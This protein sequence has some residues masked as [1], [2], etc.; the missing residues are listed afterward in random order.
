[1]ENAVWLH[2]KT[3]EFKV[4]VGELRAGEIDFVASRGA[5]RIYIQ[6]T[7]IMRPEETERREFGNLM[8]INDN[9]PKYLVPME[10]VAGEMP[11]YPGIIRMHL[12]EFLKLKL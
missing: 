1:M 7:C 2:L 6:V 4:T 10:P 12:R 8:A 11:D 9:Y 5:Q 3:Q